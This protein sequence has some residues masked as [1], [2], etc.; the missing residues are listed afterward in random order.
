MRNRKGLELALVTFCLAFTCLTAFVVGLRTTSRASDVNV[1][2]I[3]SHPRFLSF[4][5]LVFLL[6]HSR[7]KRQNCSCKVLLFTRRTSSEH[8]KGYSPSKKNAQSFS[9]DDPKRSERAPMPGA[10]QTS[11]T[12]SPQAGVV[13]AQGR[14]A[15]NNEREILC[16]PT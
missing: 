1:N 2:A 7:K 11:V 15:Y 5:P 12:T 14:P 4:Y 16:S 8:H 3:D 9:C 10:L 13:S 6:V